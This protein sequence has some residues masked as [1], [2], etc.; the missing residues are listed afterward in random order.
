MTTLIEQKRHYM[1]FVN[2]SEYNFPIF[3]KDTGVPPQY[4]LKSLMK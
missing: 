4:L 1:G 3:S 2:K